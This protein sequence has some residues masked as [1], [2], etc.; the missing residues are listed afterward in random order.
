MFDNRTKGFDDEIINKFCANKKVHEIKS[1]FFNHEDSIYWTVNVI[2]STT[3]E[4][5][6]KE[7]KS[8]VVLTE[9][10]QKLLALLKDWRR[11][12]AI[13]KGFP[14]YL[15][16]N[17]SHL[18]EIVKNRCTSLESFK[19]IRGFGKQKVANYGKEINE[20][21]RNYYEMKPISKPVEDERK[22]E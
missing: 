16:C 17:N 14:V 12:R 7:K 20:I 1:Q 21:V 6:D 22:T 13:A 3:L 8:I 2:Y 19:K 4:M 11:E 18:E 10:E 9:V 5:D 15:I